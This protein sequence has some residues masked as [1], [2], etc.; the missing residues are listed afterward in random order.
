MLTATLRPKA[1]EKDRRSQEKYGR[2]RPSHR[3]SHPTPV[4]ASAVAIWSL[5]CCV[6]SA[7]LE[8]LVTDWE[9]GDEGGGGEVGGGGDGGGWGGGGGD[10]GGEGGDSGGGGQEGTAGCAAGH[11]LWTPPLL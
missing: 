8:A 4:L 5:S 2:Q 1:D 9:D 7:K 3:P 6:G 10:A 11:E